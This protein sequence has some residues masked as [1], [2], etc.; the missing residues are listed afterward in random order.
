VWGGECVCG[1]CG[2]SVSDESNVSSRPSSG[3]DVIAFHH[4]SVS[5]RSAHDHTQP[6]PHSPTRH[7]H[8]SNSLAHH[9]HLPPKSPFGVLGGAV[10][11]GGASPH[12]DLLDHEGR[13]TSTV[14]ES[15]TG[16]QRPIYSRMGQ[17]IGES[18]LSCSRSSLNATAAR[19]ILPKV[20]SCECVCLCACTC[21]VGVG[22]R[23]FVYVSVQGSSAEFLGSVSEMY[24]CLAEMR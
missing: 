11:G 1:R 19:R 18:P 10:W 14:S 13:T 2:K 16:S 21:S 17:H 4:D 20:Y 9:A 23:S 5:P 15:S 12:R 3:Y 7:V 24:G 6:H 8:V 22:S